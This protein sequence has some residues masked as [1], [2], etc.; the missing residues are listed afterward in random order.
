LKRGRLARAGLAALLALALA[1]SAEAR[2][3]APV[4]SP[5]PPP[6]AG[7]LI[8]GVNG[9]A[10][11]DGRTLVR[12][13]GLLI[14]K[15]GHVAKLLGDGDARPERLDFRLDGHGRTLLPGLID[16]HGHL[17]ALGRRAIGL[18]LGGAHSIAALQEA[19]A[20]YA[21]ERPTPL[22]LYGAW[23]ESAAPD[24]LPTAAD[25][26]TAV[27]DRPVVLQFGG[28]RGLL[29]N[30]AAMAAAGITTKTADPVGGR[31]ARGADGRPTGLFVGTAEAL[32]LA[33]LPP[34]LPRERDEALAAAQDRLIRAGVT[35]I[36]D[37]GTSSEDWSALRRAG[38][39]GRLRVR[40]LS[41]AAGLGPLLAIAGT[42]PTPWLYDGR[43]RMVGV[44]LVADGGLGTRGAW[45]KADYADAAGVR[46]LPFLDDAKLRNLMSRAAMDGFQ[47]A[48]TA[49]GDAAVEQALGA[50]E[51]EAET[52]KGDRR[53]RIERASLVDP[54]DL[55]RF[56]HDGVIVSVQP[57]REAADRRMAE[58]RLGPVRLAG[59]PASRAV[60]KGMLAFGSD[61]QTG[62]PAPLA[63]IAAAIAE[64]GDAADAL[65][66]HTV[67]A[68]YAGFAEDRL[69]SL[70]PGTMADFVLVDRDP[71]AHPNEAAEA[72]VL[73]TWIGGKRLWVLGAHEQNVMPLPSVGESGGATRSP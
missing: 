10:F 72:R 58:V 45:L 51:E 47:V 25:L 52:Y 43:L 27:G 66:A 39:A 41:Y 49:T 37:M 61:S 15:D 62:L 2:R 34:I 44:A 6:S 18:D 60:P 63:D 33:A 55:P 16:A 35:T 17:M 68:A 13:T 7:G 73:E 40:V 56:A 69:G 23:A 59:G 54:A 26:D 22:W 9:Y 32:I 12:F 64:G 14:G 1:M 5:P 30:G 21:R 67:G 53:W 42:G 24:R 50:I 70:A 3:R 36:T 57:A 8:D 48:V 31:I 11:K 38:D 4:P 19:L 71:I 20:R 65:A 46:G 29:A 28:G